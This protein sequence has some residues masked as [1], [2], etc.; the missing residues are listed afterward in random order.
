MGIIRGDAHQIGDGE[1]WEP[2]SDVLGEVAAARL[3]HLVDE[4]AGPLADDRLVPGDLLAGEGD[5]DDAAQAGVLRRVG[6][7][8]HLLPEAEIL[9]R[10]VPHLRGPQ[11]GRE[12]PCGPAYDTDV[13]PPRHRP[14]PLARGPVSDGR[15]LVPADRRLLPETGEPCPRHP[16]GE[17]L[18]VED[19]DAELGR[20]GVD[21]PAQGAAVASP[22]RVA[23]S[24]GSEVLHDP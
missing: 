12:H 14:E 10:G 11:P 6:V 24:T 22:S 23:S 5:T 7:E 9:R 18:R 4:T 2:R 8:K 16:P 1:E 3:D 19:V 20:G 15:F 13:L 17:D 21:R